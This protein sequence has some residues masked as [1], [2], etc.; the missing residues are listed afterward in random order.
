MGHVGNKRSE[1][2]AYTHKKE[3]EDSALQGGVAI[4]VKEQQTGD[5]EDHPANEEDEE[6]LLLLWRV[7]GWHLCEE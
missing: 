6:H 3:W 2:E 1:N 7:S 4:E 5:S